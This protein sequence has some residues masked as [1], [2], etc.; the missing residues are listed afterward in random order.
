M[1]RN[2]D[3]EVDIEEVEETMQTSTRV[4]ALIAGLALSEGAL[5]E[6]TAQ[7]KAEI[8]RMDADG[9][10]VVTRAEWQGQR[11][12]F[13]QHDVNRDG[14][15]S[16]TEVWD[17]QGRPGRRNRDVE[18]FRDLDRNNDGVITTDEWPTSAARFRSLDSNRDNRITREEYRQVAATSGTFF[19]G[20]AYNA[21]YERGQGEGRA[22]G[23]ED[24]ERNQRWDLEGQ[25][26]LETADSGY[27]AR[28]GSK[29]EYQ[30][31]YRD[32]FRSAYGEGWTVR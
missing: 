2:S 14:V 10:G 17:E 25:R 21:G 31:G 3:R 30:A 7:S 26:E 27:D 13:R 20:N 5:R 19:R 18:R 32:G 22:A 29:S 6:A 23:R 11:A 4:V 1:F 28:F 24:W 15:L 12:H 16:G 8:Q 9:D